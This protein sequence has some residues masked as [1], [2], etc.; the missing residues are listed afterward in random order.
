M[1]LAGTGEI[2]VEIMSW[3]TKKAAHALS[4]M[5]QRLPALPSAFKA[6]SRGS[7]ESA[8]LCC[9]ENRLEHRG[10]LSL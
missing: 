7:I 3:T 5:L 6:V 1:T 8:R 4:L 10:A 2:L 9:P